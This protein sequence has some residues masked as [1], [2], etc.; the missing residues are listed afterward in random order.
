MSLSSSS[1]APRPKRGRSNLKTPVAYHGRG[2]AAVYAFQCEKMDKSKP[3]ICIECDAE[4]TLKAGSTIAWHFAHK[5]GHVGGCSPGESTV[6]RTAKRLIAH[7]LGHW[8]FQCVCMACREP[9]VPTASRDRSPVVTFDAKAV[10]AAE[11]ETWRAF[12]IDVGVVTASPSRTLVAAIEVKH[13]HA[14]TPEKIRALREAKVPLIEV[15]AQDVVDAYWAAR[16]NVTK[17]AALVF[18]HT[19]ERCTGCVEFPCRG[20]QKPTR[21]RDLKPE[22]RLAIAQCQP[23]RSRNVRKCDV[24][25]Q[26]QHSREQ[27]K[28]GFY[29]G[30]D[31]PHPFVIC[32]P[33]QRPMIQCPDC[34]WWRERS[35]ND[36]ATEPEQCGDCRELAAEVARMTAE[37]EAAD[38]ERREARRAVAEL[39]AKKAAAEAEQILRQRA[40]LDAK[41]KRDEEIEAARQRQEADVKAKRDAETKAARQRQEVAEDERRER[42]EQENHQR[43]IV[44]A[45]EK[46]IV[47]AADVLR[48][49]AE[50]DAQADRGD[51]KD[52]AAPSTNLILFSSPD[53][54]VRAAGSHHR[55]LFFP[56]LPPAP[57]PMAT[58]KRKAPPAGQGPLDTF[59]TKR[60]RIT[61]STTA[62][63]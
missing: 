5:K 38:E 56:P 37:R 26:W 53:G 36:G 60:P 21:K 47:D 57:Q 19:H 52:T 1:T 28:S 35:T 14:S 45:R 6:H 22:N 4:L 31:G 23:C 11:E 41:A 13:T 29:A 10:C 49:R 50:L 17:F 12:R 27:W 18:P 63:R 32:T 59:F 34:Y 55:D 15:S 58:N 51:R 40:E 9:L 43:S 30:H 2:G 46:A 54:T 62:T 44:A 7:Y 16:G 42:E 25:K 20:C 48:R 3:Y 39:E 8:Q 24:C 33:C 61:S